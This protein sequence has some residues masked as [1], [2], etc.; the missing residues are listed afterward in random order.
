M[1]PYLYLF[2]VLFVRCKIILTASSC[3]ASWPPALRNTN[4]HATHIWQDREWGGITYV[5]AHRPLLIIVTID[6]KLF[7][8]V[9]FDIACPPMFNLFSR[10]TRNS[11]F[12][13]DFELTLEGPIISQLD[14]KSQ[15]Q[16]V[17]TIGDGP[18]GTRWNSS[19]VAPLESHS[20]PRKNEI[21]RKSL[22]S[23]A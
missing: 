1:E 13:L 15:R 22:D 5:A 21:A 6:S 7:D 17:A 16:C 11:S 12:D 8:R 2:S 14:I 10:R 23:C 19:L 18:R 3:A 9:I 20:S 4:C